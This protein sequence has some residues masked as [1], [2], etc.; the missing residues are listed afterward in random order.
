MHAMDDRDDFPCVVINSKKG[1][2]GKGLTLPDEQNQNRFF[3][4]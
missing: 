2:D 3:L 4:Q 1:I